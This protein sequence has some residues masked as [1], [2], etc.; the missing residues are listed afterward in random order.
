MIQ[1][2]Q[3]VYLFLVS[4]IISCIWMFKIQINLTPIIPLESNA[5]LLNVL[6]GA[7]VILSL[8]TLFLFKNRNLQLLFSKLLVGLLFLF[9][10]LAIFVLYHSKFDTTYFTLFI[11]VVISFILSIRAMKSIKH[12][13]DLINSADRLR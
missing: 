12:D 13:I 1:R 6:V 5:L 8:I 11:I 4:L 7:V 9:S 3:S 10:T 2:I